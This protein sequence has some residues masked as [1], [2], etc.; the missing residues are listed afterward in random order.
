MAFLLLLAGAARGTSSCPEGKGLCDCLSSFS[1]S[2]HTDAS[3]KVL[4]VPAGC[5]LQWISA[6]TSQGVAQTISDAAAM[7]PSM[8]LVKG[9]GPGA[10]PAGDENYVCRVKFNV[11]ALVMYHNPVNGDWTDTEYHHIDGDT[12]NNKMYVGRLSTADDEYPEQCYF[13]SPHAD[14]SG[15][16]EEFRAAQF[17]L[18]GA[19]CDTWAWSTPGAVSGTVYTSTERASGNSFCATSAICALTDTDGTGVLHPGYASGA[20]RTKA[21][22]EFC[23]DDGADC[24]GVCAGCSACA[25]APERGCAEPESPAPTPAPTATPTTAAPTP[26]PTEPAPTETPGGAGNDETASET[27]EIDPGLLTESRALTSAVVVLGGMLA[28]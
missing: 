19:S 10:G 11:D 27:D 3:Y 26:A 8:N 2:A 15:G 21:C 20:D 17:Q 24:A 4:D 6:R 13:G 16:G 14:E 18:L 22:E 23:T 7:T 28:A 9:K 5:T 25:D 1:G 12:N